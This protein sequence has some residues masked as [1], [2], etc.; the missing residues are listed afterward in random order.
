MNEC[1]IYMQENIIRKKWK[2][3]AKKAINNDDIQ[4]YSERK[5]DKQTTFNKTFHRKH[6]LSKRTTLKY[7]VNLVDWNPQVTSFE[8]NI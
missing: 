1:R 7:K 2:E 8:L 5:E 6:W 4:H 3:D